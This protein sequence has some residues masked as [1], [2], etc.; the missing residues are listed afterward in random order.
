MG[1]LIFK[2]RDG[3]EYIYNDDYGVIYEN[4]SSSDAKCKYK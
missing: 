1:K 3:V 4:I 2:S